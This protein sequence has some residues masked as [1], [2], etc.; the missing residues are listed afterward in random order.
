MRKH[1]TLAAEVALFPQTRTILLHLEK[2]KSISPMEAMITYGVTRLAARIR[3][4]RVAGFQISTEMRRDAVS[5]PY[6]RYHLA[7]A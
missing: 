1:P 4:L 7:A 2:H 5:K 3:E 6:A